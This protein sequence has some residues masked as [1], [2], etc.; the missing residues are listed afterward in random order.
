ME[1]IL[2]SILVWAGL[3]LLVPG[4]AQAEGGTCPPGYYPHNIPGVMGC[5]PIP[6]YS[7]GGDPVDPGPQWETRW[8]AIAIGNGGYGTASDFSSKR[9]AKKQALSECK[10]SGAQSCKISVLYYNQC[11][12]LAW[13]ESKMITYRSPDKADAEA[14]VLESCG[15]ITENCRVFYSSCNYPARI[16]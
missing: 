12:A 3:F 15:R 2:R 13:G 5:A 8:G 6:G 1:L 4:L 10:K 14:R 11:A 9:K 7:P 16:R